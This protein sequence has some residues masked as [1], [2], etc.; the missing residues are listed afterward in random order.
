MSGALYLTG[1]L[2]ELKPFV[3]ILSESIGQEIHTNP[4]ARYAGSIGG[5]LLAKKLV[6]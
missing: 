3:Q 2:C 1:G 6:I 4:L 5:A